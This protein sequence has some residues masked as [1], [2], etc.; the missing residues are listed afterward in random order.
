MC[1]RSINS[2]VIHEFRRLQKESQ[3][4]I[5][6]R[7]FIK[8]KMDSITDRN[9]LFDSDVENNAPKKKIQNVSAEADRAAEELNMKIVLVSVNL[10]V[11]MALKSDL[12][13]EL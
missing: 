13:M 9:R 10:E 1:Q 12:C 11:E 7:N 6:G 2:S 5:K 4:K 3:Q 8:A